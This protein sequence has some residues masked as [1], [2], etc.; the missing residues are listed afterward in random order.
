MRPPVFRRPTTRRPPEFYKSLEA[1]KGEL[2]DRGLFDQV[3]RSFTNK[4][5]LTCLYNLNSL[6]TARAHRELYELMKGRYFEELGVAGR[7]ASYFFSESDYAQYERVSSLSWEDY[8][9]AENLELKSKLKSS[10]RKAKSLQKKLDAATN[11]S[12]SSRQRPNR[13]LAPKWSRGSGGASG[14]RVA[15]LKKA[16]AI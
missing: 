5:L 1:L 16:G 3:E 14:R 6:K 9:F 15:M 10:R 4:A 2:I 13:S 8:V 7:E 12:E 11:R